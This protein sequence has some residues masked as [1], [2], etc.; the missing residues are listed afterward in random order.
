MSPPIITYPFRPSDQGSFFEVYI[1]KRA[2]YYGT[3]FNALRYG[4]EEAIVKKYLR[5]SVAHLLVEFK[6]L[7]DLFNPQRYTEAE[8]RQEPVTEQEA[9]E[10]I[11]MYKSHFKGWSI[12]AV[13]GVWFNEKKGSKDYGKSFEEATQVI[14][15]MFRYESPFEKKAIDTGC[16]DVLRAI[17]VWLCERVR[18]A[19][20][21]TWDKEEEDRF[22]AQHEPWPEHKLA[23]VKRY[24]KK[25]AKHVG[26]WF[27]DNVLFIFGYLVRKFWTGIVEEGLVEYEIWITSFYD[28]FINAIKRVEL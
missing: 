3:I 4:Y 15:I 2:A 23:F 19:N 26:K 10:R 14:R 27:D 5:E 7:P 18:L 1:P 6:S 20:H 13:D 22:I 8:I 16:F 28:L 21:K 9:R 17:L 12:H 25:I 11:E 24:F